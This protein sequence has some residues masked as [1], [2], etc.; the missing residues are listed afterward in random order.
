MLIQSNN[1]FMNS[2]ESIFRA[3]EAVPDFSGRRITSV[4]DQNGYGDTPLHIVS[5]WGDSE[6]IEVLL[7]AGADINAVGETGFTPLHCAVEQNHF[8]AIEV[9]VRSGAILIKDSNDQTPLE[10]AELLGHK[11][12]VQALKNTVN[13]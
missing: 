10:L 8:E 5:C 7:A 3:I 6:A 11:E 13:K 9:L 2:I 1:H 12:A 4:N